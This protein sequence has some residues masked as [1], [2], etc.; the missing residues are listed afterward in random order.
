MV[1]TQKLVQTGPYACTRNPM[2]LGALSMYLG[3]GIWM[4]SG[5]VIALALI[6]F[7]VLLTYIYVHETR[8]S[9][10]RFREVYLEYVKQTPFLFPHCRKSLTKPD[11][12]RRQ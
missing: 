5:I 3:I 9:S 6:V 10:G 2:T 4:G 1:A 7:S 11:L 12:S 8:E